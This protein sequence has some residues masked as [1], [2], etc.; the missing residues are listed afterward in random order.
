MIRTI[1]IRDDTKYKVSMSHGIHGQCSNCTV[2]PQVKKVIIRS[3]VWSYPQFAESLRSCDWK[4][5]IL[6]FWTYTMILLRLF[7][8]STE[9][10]R[11]KNPHWLAIVRQNLHDLRLKV[12]DHDYNSK[13][14]NQAPYCLSVDFAMVVLFTP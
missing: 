11:S 1:L 7:E 12:Y 4:Y 13:F 14:N 8:H 3:H 6:R 9:N 2:S 10:I 5:T